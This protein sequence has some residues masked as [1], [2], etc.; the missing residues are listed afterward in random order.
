V[1]WT[2]AVLVVCSLPPNATAG[3]TIAGVAVALVAFYFGV[4]RRRF[5]GPKLDLAT[6]ERQ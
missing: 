2:I 4:V 6:L 5:R 1:A 3:M